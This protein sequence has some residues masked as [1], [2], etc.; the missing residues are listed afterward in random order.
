MLRNI[1]NKIDQVYQ[2]Q[3]LCLTTLSAHFPGNAEVYP[4]RDQSRPVRLYVSSH[5]Y[6]NMTDSLF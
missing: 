3:A 1:P 4:R 5:W 2:P 6:A